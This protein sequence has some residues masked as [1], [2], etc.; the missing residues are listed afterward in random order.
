MTPITDPLAIYEAVR[1]D[2]RAEDDAALR[3]ELCRAGRYAVTLEGPETY[4][5]T[6]TATGRHTD[7]DSMSEATL[8]AQWVD[9]LGLPEAQA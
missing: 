1:Q 3:G 9:S 5:V 8:L 2:Q 4:R 7:M 6:D